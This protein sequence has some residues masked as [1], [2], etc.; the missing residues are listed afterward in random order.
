MLNYY[1][2]SPTNF[3]KEP[4]LPPI[5]TVPYL[6]QSSYIQRLWGLF[7]AQGTLVNLPL[8]GSA[9]FLGFG[10]HRSCVEYTTPS[11]L[12]KGTFENYP[13]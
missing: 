10:W 13:E 2:N 12:L 9:I 7:N 5:P 4:Q 11:P 6:Y 8:K 1:E 3:Q